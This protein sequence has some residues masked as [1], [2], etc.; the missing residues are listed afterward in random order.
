MCRA[1]V[2]APDVTI[3]YP[4]A[5]VARRRDWL[6]SRH[7]EVADAQWSALSLS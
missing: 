2:N 5:S 6:N 4:R 1:D 3:P 7:G